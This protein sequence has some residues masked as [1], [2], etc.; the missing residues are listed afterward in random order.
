MLFF[1]LWLNEAH[2]RA[3][4]SNDDGL[5]I[6]RIVLLTL[7]KRL[8]V[9]RGD[10]SDLMPKPT[11]LASPVMRAAASFHNDHGGSCLA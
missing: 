5:G 6:C 9:M 4:G 7:Y 10:Q 1:G 2:L 3:L 11:Y 8:H